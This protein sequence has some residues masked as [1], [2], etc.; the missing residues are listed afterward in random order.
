MS[1]RAA[2]TAAPTNRAADRADHM[3]IV[4]DGKIPSL[5]IREWISAAVDV[6]RVKYGW[7]P[8]IVTVRIGDNQASERYIRSQLKACE[9]VGCTARFEQFKAGIPKEDFLKALA[10]IGRDPDVDGIILQRPFPSGW[11][12]EEI[13]NGLPSS[14]DVEGVHPENLGRL[15]LGESGI[16][17]PCTAWAAISLLEWYGRSTF[18]HKRCVVVGRSPNVGRAA[19]IML[20]HRNATVTICHTRTSP[21]H[22]RDTLK[23]AD[24]AVI[25]AGLAGVVRTSDFSDR[26]WVVDVGTN[27]TDDG[28][29][30]GD[31][32]KDADGC[33]EALSPVPGGVGP[34]TVSLL[35][36]NLLLCASRRRLGK[37][38]MLPNLFELRGV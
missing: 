3:T 27:V 20:M 37:R 10:A 17:L 18:E 7:R 11:H 28:R 34:I 21:E 12:A 24:I 29:L 32:E 1:G 30:V 19:A 9:S 8:G 25:A 22:M 33:V 36:A 14:K 6:M 31:V 4:L 5:K 15:Y 13:L 23:S 16:P 26:A 38:L 35:L 2:L